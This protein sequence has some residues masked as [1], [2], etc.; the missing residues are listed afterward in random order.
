MSASTLHDT[1]CASR[2]DG[3]TAYLN[4][5]SSVMSSTDH[6]RPYQ[7]HMMNTCEVSTGK[8]IKSSTKPMTRRAKKGCIVRELP[9]VSKWS[10]GVLSLAMLQHRAIPS[11]RPWRSIRFASQLSHQNDGR[12]LCTFCYTLPTRTEFKNRSR[13][14]DGG[15]FWHCRECAQALC[16]TI[17]YASNEH[18]PNGL[19]SMNVFFPVGL[20]DK[21]QPRIRRDSDAEQKSH[22]AHV[23]VAAAVH[24]TPRPRATSFISAR[25]AQKRDHATEKWFTN[26]RELDISDVG[27]PHGLKSQPRKKH[28]MSEFPKQHE[29]RPRTDLNALFGPSTAR[30]AT[31]LR[32]QSRRELGGDYASYIP[33]GYADPHRFP[34]TYARSV[35]GRNK[36]IPLNAQTGALNIIEEAIRG[37][38]TRQGESAL[39]LFGSDLV[40]DRAL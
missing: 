20:S 16:Y 39:V 38:T 37:T 2:A 34:I 23:E 21:T 5:T 33:D 15:D 10:F 28:M 13:E 25:S 26:V 40:E 32:L 12:H 27:Q 36:H 31:L 6:S 8:S 22:N 29:M 7:G 9:H 35:L 30:S 19:S 1:S 18:T 3:G 4:G 17:A 14:N 11:T 24:G